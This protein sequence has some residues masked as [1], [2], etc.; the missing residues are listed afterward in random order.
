MER[1]LLRRLLAFSLLTLMLAL[2]GCGSETGNDSPDS[3]Q[4]GGSGAEAT[5]A[6]DAS[7]TAEEATGEFTIVTDDG[8]VTRNDNIYTVTAAGTYV[9]S[10][11]LEGQVVVSA[12][13]DDVVVL[14]LAGTT[15]T[16]SSDSPIRIL[17]ADKVEISAQKDTANII[18]DTR[19][20]KVSD[21]TAQGEGAISAKADLKLKGM[22]VL[23]VNGGYNN[24]VHTTKDLAVQKLS[25]KV[26]AYNNALKGSDSIKIKSGT[27]IAISTNGDG[28]KTTD[29]K[30]NKSGIVRG[31]VVISGGSVAVYAAGDGI[32]AAHNFELCADEEGNTAVVSI[33]TGSYSGYTA[34]NANTTSYKGVKAKNEI[35]IRAGEINVSSFDDGLHA[36]YGAVIEAG[37]VGSGSISIYGGTV[38]MGVYAPEGKTGGGHHG[39]GGWGGQKKVSGA[40]GIHADGTLMIAGGTLNID[41]AYEGL[42]AN[43]IDISGGSTVVAASDDGVNAC[44][45]VQ[46]PKVIVSG[47]YL[48]VSVSPNGDVDGIDS[49]GSY[50]QTGGVVIA[51]GPNREMAAAI[52]AENGVSITGGTLVVLGFGRVQTGGSVTSRTLSVHSAGSHTVTVGGKEY[53][54][55]NSYDYGQTACYSDTEVSGS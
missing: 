10:G 44:K 27:V 53:A 16:N 17:S 34:E 30:A 28:M 9:L 25:L 6:T 12:G 19:N 47:G 35:V 36:D 1:S 43:V 49:N 29:T 15:I 38:N 39:P 50:T 5:P 55:A 46:P 31:D 3:T 23:V 21:T 51:R 37:G 45:G 32:Q 41:S 42:E 33:F 4:P 48:D 26:T 13:D 11:A 14:E 52:D 54:F 18:N 40:D 22:G 2:A 8:A 7:I 24:G 20:A